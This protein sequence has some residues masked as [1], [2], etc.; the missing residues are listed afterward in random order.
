[1]NMKVYM[2]V[3]NDC[4]H[5]SRVL[6]E[7][8]T[9]AANGYD[10]TILALPGENS[11]AHEARD[12]FQIARIECG[13]LY[14][15]AR[16]LV[17]NR[18]YETAKRD[19]ASTASA[20]TASPLVLV[21]RG[22]YKCVKLVVRW[23]GRP[24]VVT[25]YSRA[26]W[27]IIK[28]A[29]ADIYHSHDLEMLPVG[30]TASRRTK[31]KSVYDAHEL[32]TELRYVPK[33]QRV[34]FGLI[35]RILVHRVDAM[36]TT[37]DVVADLYSRRYGIRKPTVLMN[38]PTYNPQRLGNSSNGLRATLGVPLGEPIII[39]SGGLQQDRGLEQMVDAMR[40]LD[41]G[42]LVFLGWGYQE[43]LLRDLAAA[44]GLD[45]RVIFC[46]PVP[47]DK[48]SEYISS[49]SVGIIC[50]QNTSLNN[51]YTS[52][53]KLFEY[54]TA[55]LPVVASDFP[56]LRYVIETHRIGKACDPTSPQDIARALAWVLS[57]EY[58]YQDLRAN[59]LKAAAVFN[60]DN[61]ARKLV[62]TYRGL[63]TE[64]D[65]KG[66]DHANRRLSIVSRL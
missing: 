4:T 45:K 27:R 49:A 25:Q 20:N 50:T 59:V 5:D 7:A 37:N 46:P 42:V 13:N 19:D 12:G 55:G 66:D 24:F 22:F 35:E 32:Y 31:G 39:Y 58:R 23:L 30:Y 53:N 28:R 57:D 26:A 14:N 52:P 16:R 36:I 10:V 33:V 6:K 29:P 9:L 34:I 1:M 63:A 3:L 17:G 41:R 48:V 61:E 18:L 51:Y 56:F 15:L 11:A 40:F 65:E 38:C 2:F 62:N 64:C 54:L 21:R 60:W 44:R 8:Q 47:S 43:S